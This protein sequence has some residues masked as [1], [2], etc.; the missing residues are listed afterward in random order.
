MS[1][2]DELLEHH[3]LVIRDGRVVDIL[4]HG[5]AEERYAASVEA[6]RP[7]HLLMPGLINARTRIE[8]PPGAAAASAEAQADG[9][10]LALACMIRAGVTCFCEVGHRPREAAAMAA[11]QGLRAVIGLPLDHR[12]S[13]WARDQSGYLSRA[14]QLR[15]EWK[16]HPSIST[17]FAPLE[18]AQLADE[19]LAR[20]GTLAEELDAGILAS[21]H[22]SRHEV[23]ES[24]RRHGRRPLARLDALGLL[25]PALTAAHMTQLDPE[26]LALARRS[27][28][29]VTLCLGSSLMRG[30]GVPPIGALAAP[31]ALR[32]CLGT[33]AEFL[34]PGYD[35]WSEIRLLSLHAREL[36]PGG[37]LGAATR[38]GAAALGL[39]AEVGTLERGKWADVACMDLGGPATSPPA[40]PLRQLVYCGGRDLVSDVWVAGRPLLAEGRFTRID[41]PQLAARLGAD[42]PQ[43]KRSTAT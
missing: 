8:A 15:D 29:A 28:I 10:L 19:T 38:G 2:D 27:G 14:L 12:A 1:G 5:A 13:G 26:D 24:L 31:P 37:V 43:P 3:S 30:Q 6:V 35:P 22:A 20:M 32:L 33:D 17:R 41:W 36:H 23:E 40:E 42:G 39:D 34:G 25:S 18:L 16:G 11:A 7:T 4:P 9:A 21:L